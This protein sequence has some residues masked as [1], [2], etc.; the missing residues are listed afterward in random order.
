M[1]EEDDSQKTEDP[2]E[3]KISKA[4]EKG[5]VGTSQEVKSWAILMGSLLTLS[6][7][8]PWM[9][10][11]IKNYS[12]GFIENSHAINTD[13]GNL[14]EL[15]IDVLLQLGVYLS[16]IFIVLMILAF[17]ASVMQSGF[18]WA[19]DKIAPKLNKISLASGFKRM[20]SSRALVEFLKGI[21]KLGIVTVLMVAMALP[22]VT[23]LELMSG[24][25]LVDVVDRMFYLTI[26]IST[27]AIMVMT[28]IAVLDYA[29]Q[30][31]DHNKSL[32]M[33]RQE[34]KDEHKESEGDP[35]IKARIRKIRSE[36]AQQ[37]MMSAVPKAD[38]VIT[39]PTHYSIA[40]EYKMDSMAA[41]RV[42]AK[43][44][45][46]L[47]LKIRE[48]AKENDIPIVENVPLARALYSAAEID[49]EIP[50]E[51]YKAVAEVIGYVMRLK[52]DIPEAEPESTIQ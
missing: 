11:G 42:L 14:Q 18:L 16:P 4:R 10:G 52:G 1:A 46:H 3:R 5:Q 39:N 24:Y 12:V 29:Y 50:V 26:A 6:I 28:A 33:S 8:A 38:V 43:G 32:K 2:T 47:A 20:F 45:D 35:Q 17:A 13:V 34:V 40:L 9:M 30:K 22:F 25:A 48:V 31:F 23:D 49:E 51:H 7:M 19:P 41:P 21:L 36:R 15:L 37:R 27:G 44:I